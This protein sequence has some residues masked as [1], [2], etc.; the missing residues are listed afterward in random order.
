MGASGFLGKR[1]EERLTFLGHEV[2][3]FVR[4][5]PNPGPEEAFWNPKDGRLNRNAL[6]SC[7]VVIHLGGANIANKRWSQARKEVLRSSR[8]ESTKLLAETMAELDGGPQVL[9]SASAIGYYGSRADEILE[10]SAPQGTGFLAALCADWEG[11]TKPALD[12][13]LRV[14]QMRIGMVIGKDGGAL[15]KMAVPFRFGLGGKLG[16]GK[17]WMS[18]IGIDDVVGI[19]VAAVDNADFSGPINVVAPGTVTNADFTQAL[20]AALGKPTLFPAPGFVLRMALG[21]MASE[22]L[23]ASNRVSSQKVEDLGYV[24]QHPELSGALEHAL[25]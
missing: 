17:Q 25:S 9:I 10:E 23:L 24:F 7:D 16:N 6:R 13:G 21:Q 4:R 3:C 12:A 1:L 20:G 5:R 15:A 14:A 19:L 22:L 8:V 2:L 11:A 18:W